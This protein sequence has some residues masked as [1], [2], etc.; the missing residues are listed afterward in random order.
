MLSIILSIL[1]SP[2]FL[3]LS[4]SIIF[5]LAY[6]NNQMKQKENFE[7]NFNMN[8]TPHVNYQSCKENKSWI[9]NETLLETGQD[10]FSKNQ[11]LVGKKQ[12]PRTYSAPLIVPPSYD[13]KYWRKNNLT[14]YPSIMNRPRQQDLYLSGYVSKT[15]ENSDNRKY[16]VSSYY[17][18]YTSVGGREE[19]LAN[20]QDTAKKNIDRMYAREYSHGPIDESVVN[21]EYIENNLNGGYKDPFRKSCQIPNTNINFVNSDIKNPC[22]WKCNP[23][24]NQNNEFQNLTPVSQVSSCKSGMS[25]NTI[26]NFEY[27]NDNKYNNM[28]HGSYSNKKLDSSPKYPYYDQVE[29][30]PVQNIGND[31]INKEC[32]YNPNYIN[33]NLPVNKCV[34]EKQLEPEYKKYNNDQSIQIVQ[35]GMYYKSQVLDPINSNIGI[36]YNQQYLPQTSKNIGPGE[37]LYTDHDP[38]QYVGETYIDN[39]ITGEELYN[40][41]DPRLTGYGSNDR[42]YF[43]EMTGQPR[44]FYDDIDAVKRPSYI[45]RSNVDHLGTF[46]QTGAMKDGE[47]NFDYRSNANNEFHESTL[48]LR[49][50]I[51]TRLAQKNYARTSQL[52]DMPLSS[53]GRMR[54]R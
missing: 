27:I 24:L 23:P 41:Y 34:G 36:S 45:V 46:D 22:T 7:Y 20:M 50:D 29:Y 51:Q 33:Y 5:I 2:F 52:R 6:I 10:F 18:P 25:E 11:N 8:S 32:G 21:G 49:S 4:L 38:E 37:V 16:N 15:D 19:I 43:D 42:Y 1:S 3:I 14:E 40:I 31:Y 30:D 26:E 54:G 28:K 53:A 47:L 12:H 9:S 48:D 35:P 44:F 17:D 13:L 39:K